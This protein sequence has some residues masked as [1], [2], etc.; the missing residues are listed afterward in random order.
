MSSERSLFENSHAETWLEHHNFYDTKC[1]Y[2]S[3][4]TI[5]K[6]LWHICSLYNYLCKWICYFEEHPQGHQ[7]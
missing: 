5:W 3:I 4:H 2:V 6:L 1:R 7:A